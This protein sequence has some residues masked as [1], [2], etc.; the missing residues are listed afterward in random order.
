MLYGLW[1]RESDDRW[2]HTGVSISD[3]GFHKES[4]GSL[5]DVVMF[6]HLVYRGDGW[7]ASKAPR[8][9][10]LVLP[11]SAS[12][13]CSWTPVPIDNLRSSLRWSH[14]LKVPRYT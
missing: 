13:M 5:K 9:D 2:G 4:T 1:C 14:L 8:I 12:P 10:D 6:S 7:P 3:D 11:A